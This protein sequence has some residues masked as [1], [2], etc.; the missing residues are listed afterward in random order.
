MHS[1]YIRERVLCRPY[2]LRVMCCLRESW[3]DSKRKPSCR[4]TTCSS[5]AR[6]NARRQCGS[7]S[8]TDRAHV[9]VSSI[10]PSEAGTTVLCLVMLTIMNLEA[11]PPARLFCTPRLAAG[12]DKSSAYD[13]IAPLRLYLIR[14]HQ[15]NWLNIWR[16]TTS[17]VN[18]GMHAFRERRDLQL[19]EPECAHLD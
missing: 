3:L 15:E 17:S 7:Y 12:P 1:L 19:Y 10:N 4:D 18:H 5:R 13:W 8:T 9:L 2:S 16:Y 14:H 6:D 11:H